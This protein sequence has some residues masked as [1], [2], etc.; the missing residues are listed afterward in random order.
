MKTIIAL[1][2]LMASNCFGQADVNLVATGDW[3]KPVRDENGVGSVLR[4]R[5]LIYDDQAQ[6]AANHARLYIEIQQVFTNGWYDPVEIYFFGT[7]LVFELHNEH[8]QPISGMATMRMGAVLKPY[9]VT[10]PCDGTV[11]IRADECT[12]G[13]KEKPDGLEILTRDNCWIVPLNATNDFYLTC[14][15]TS[16][17][18]YPS[19]LHY[20]TWRGTLR[21][22]KVK[23]PSQNSIGL[24]FMKPQPNPQG[25]ANRSQPFSS[26]TN[27][28]SGAAASGRSP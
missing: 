22:P 19:P 27:R 11:R 28:A 2:L 23:I 12:L 18:N 15:F 5:L 1:A 14:S 3:T 13:P 7:N 16:A 8:G 26:E 21:F 6:S 20:D 4:G 25:G 10:V 24:D 17:T 9:W